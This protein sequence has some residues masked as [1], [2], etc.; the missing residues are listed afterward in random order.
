MYHALLS[1][2]RL[3]E[4]LHKQH[5]QEPILLRQTQRKHLS[6]P[7]VVRQCS[8]IRVTHW[9]DTRSLRVHEVDDV[10]VGALEDLRDGSNA[11]VMI[12]L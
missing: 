6:T 11:R 8:T 3:L 9:R 1:S 2:I 5:R 4:K 12:D 10:D 7:R